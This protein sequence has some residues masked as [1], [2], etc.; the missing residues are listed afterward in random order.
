MTKYET[1]SKKRFFSPIAALSNRL[2]GTRSPFPASPKQRPLPQ[3]LDNR[4]SMQVMARASDLGPTNQA[5]KELLQ[6]AACRSKFRQHLRK[7]HMDEALDCLDDI[8]RCH[9]NPKL[10]RN[11][12][13]TYCLDTSP[14]QVNLSS[15]NK[16]WL[17]SAL[18]ANNLAGPELFLYTE[19]ELL[20]DIRQSDA[21]RFFLGFA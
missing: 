12:I 8:A 11:I 13:L 4:H 2:S 7:L 14:R 18:A 6:D 1:N 20:K 5:L 16:H 17:T 19:M 15:N 10:A 3:D 21:F 9:A